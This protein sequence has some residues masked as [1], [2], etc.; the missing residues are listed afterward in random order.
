MFD[1]QQVRYAGMEPIYTKNWTEID[2]RNRCYI[3][4]H[5]RTKEQI[6]KKIAVILG[7][8]APSSLCLL[9]S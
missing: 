7:I 4:L 1:E 2:R 3:V 8:H 9:N 5:W 6:F